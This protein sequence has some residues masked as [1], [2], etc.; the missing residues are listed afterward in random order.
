MPRFIGHRNSGSTTFD[1]MSTDMDYVRTI[2]IIAFA[3]VLGSAAV[4]LQGC[5]AFT[6]CGPDPDPSYNTVDVK[7]SD[8]DKEFFVAT[9][10]TRFGQIWPSGGLHVLYG[11][12]K[13]LVTGNSGTKIQASGGGRY[14]YL[15]DS[16][17]SC[18]G[19]PR[20]ETLTCL[21]VSPGTIATTDSQSE[22]IGAARYTLFRY[23]DERFAEPEILSVSRAQPLGDDKYSIR[24]V[25]ERVFSSDGSYSMS[26]SQRITRRFVR[27]THGQV[28]V[29]QLFAAD[30]VEIV[31]RDEKDGTESTTYAAL[32]V[33]VV[34]ENRPLISDTGTHAVFYF[35]DGRY[36]SSGHNGVVVDLRNPD[37]F[38]SFER[39]IIALSGSGIWVSE[40]SNSSTSTFYDY[41]KPLNLAPTVV[42]RPS[43]PL[44]FVPGI[45]DA[46]V[47]TSGGLYRF[48]PDGGE[49]R[50]VLDFNDIKDYARYPRAENEPF[51]HIVSVTASARDPLTIHLLVSFY[52][53]CGGS[54]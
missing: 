9:L 42:E 53:S 16:T 15:P 19:N 5:D 7:L 51:G 39:R 4:A 3:A 24:I 31:V 43:G 35:A 46:L 17:V 25:G 10:N 37:I 34:P 48:D 29:E 47:L 45:A 27:D 23:S 50:K 36:S 21:A 8:V 11:G 41:E 28:A 1:K 6:S 22:P 14:Y 20:D 54:A 52:H 38:L 2:S 18:S 49:P 26:W 12:K 30:P 13:L 32:S 40:G 44:S 33:E